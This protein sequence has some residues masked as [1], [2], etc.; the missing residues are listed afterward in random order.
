MGNKK[1]RDEAA[2]PVSTRH[3]RMLV[4]IALIWHLAGL[5]TG[6]ACLLFPELAEEFIR[7]LYRG[8]FLPPQAVTV[9]GVIAFTVLSAISGVS[10][11]FCVRGSRLSFL[12]YSCC[13]I[14]FLTG[15]LLINLGIF[16]LPL[17]VMGIAYLLVLK[18]AMPKTMKHSKNIQHEMGN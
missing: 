8:S 9:Y 6:L 2:L 18:R 4:Y 1:N 15:S 11:V 7:F 13:C 3:L 14:L 5:A 10:A 17:V 12:I 16:N